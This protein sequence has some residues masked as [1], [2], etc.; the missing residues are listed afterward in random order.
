MQLQ[1]VKWTFSST[2]MDEKKHN[3]AWSWFLINLKPL[4]IKSKLNILTTVFVY[5]FL[6]FHNCS[7]IIGVKYYFL[8]LGLVHIFAMKSRLYVFL[9]SN[10]SFKL[11]Y[12]FF[13][14]QCRKLQN[15]KVSYVISESTHQ[16]RTDILFWKN[17]V[18]ITTVQDEV[19]LE[20]NG[21]RIVWVNYVDT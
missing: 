2:I 20:L 21:A 12:A 19:V 13:L 18:I 1:I 17:H 15:V 3:T 5:I 9:W 16:N 7:I 14:N 10:T 8:E 6:A 4:K 11:F